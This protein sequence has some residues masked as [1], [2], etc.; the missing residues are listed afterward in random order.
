MKRSIGYYFLIVI[1]F[2]LISCLIYQLAIKGTYMYYKGVTAFI[3]LE[4][5]EIFIFYKLNKNVNNLKLNFYFLSSLILNFFLINYF[6]YLGEKYIEILL[7][8]SLLLF[9]ILLYS[10]LLFLIEEN[11]F[12]FKYTLISFSYLLFLIYLTVP[13]IPPKKEEIG[14]I[15][16]IFYI[17]YVLMIFLFKEVEK[18][19][20]NKLLIFINKDEKSNKK[21]TF[22]I[23]R[24]LI[25]SLL[26]YISIRYRDIHYKIILFF[27]TFELFGIIIFYKKNF[28]IKNLMKKIE[29][30]LLFN[31]FMILI[32]YYLGKIRE[33]FFVFTEVIIMFSPFFL[34]LLSLIYLLIKKM[35]FYLI[36]SLILLLWGLFFIMPNFAGL[37]PELG[38]YKPS[39][40][41]IFLTCIVVSYLYIPLFK[42]NESKK[43]EK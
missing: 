18:R 36:Y 29:L 8:L 38:E 19:N 32:F 39:I 1:K 31:F 40:I 24:I 33:E 41:Y 34:A 25:Y 11:L 6:Y 16:G 2:F 5:L 7:F 3:L 26:F 23:I 35:K 28:F 14:Y 4:L 20:K 37:P 10:F 17:V 42:K 15:V 13:I 30:Y 21:H 22:N 12:Y 43:T 9:F 27:I